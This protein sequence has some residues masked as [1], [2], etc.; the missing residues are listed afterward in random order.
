MSEPAS[1]GQ[2]YMIFPV[3]MLTMF[4]L[5]SLANNFDRFIP[6]KFFLAFCLWFILLWELNVLFR[7]Q[8]ILSVIPFEDNPLLLCL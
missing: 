3:V 5:D 1:L 8:I 4:G 7:F 6:I 2:D